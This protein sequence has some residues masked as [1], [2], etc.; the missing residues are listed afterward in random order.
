MK[1]VSDGNTQILQPKQAGFP[2]SATEPVLVCYNDGMKLKKD[3]VVIGL[4][5]LLIAGFSVFSYFS[6]NSGERVIIRRDGETVEDVPLNRD[7]RYEI[8]DEDGEVTNIVVVEDGEAYMLE[9]TCPDHL[10]LSM[11]KIDSDGETVVCLPNRVVVEIEGGEASE[12]DM[13]AK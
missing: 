3:Y 10:C 12:V 2:D 6:R 8:R 7:G 11:G 5:V 4:A 9:A 13:T 1:P